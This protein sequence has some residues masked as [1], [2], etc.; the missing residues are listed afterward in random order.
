VRGERGREK[1]ERESQLGNR[2]LGRGRFQ[3]REKE[4]DLN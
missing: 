1:E 3:I 4:E 2:E